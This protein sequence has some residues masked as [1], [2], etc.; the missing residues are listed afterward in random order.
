MAYWGWVLFLFNEFFILI[1]LLNF[2]IAIIGQSYDEV[3]SKEEI[4]RYNS[5][6]D[7]NIEVA[8]ILDTI[9]EWTNNK[10]EKSHRIFYLVANTYHKDDENEF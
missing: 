6:C 10:A 8:I 1:V 5:R 9:K 3:M 4:D 7:L 2:L